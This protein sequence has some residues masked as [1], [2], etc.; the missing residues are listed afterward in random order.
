MIQKPG[1]YQPMQGREW[2]TMCIGP[3]MSSSPSQSHKSSKLTPIDAFSQWKPI[4]SLLDVILTVKGDPGVFTVD[5]LRL[6]RNYRRIYNRLMRLLEIYLW[7]WACVKETP[8]LMAAASSVFTGFLK[9]RSELMALKLL[10]SWTPT[11]RAAASRMAATSSSL[12]SEKNKIV[13][14][15]CVDVNWRSGRK[16][17]A[18]GVKKSVFLLIKLLTMNFRLLQPRE[19]AKHVAGHPTRGRERECVLTVS[20]RKCDVTETQR[21]SERCAKWLI[22][23]IMP[24]SWMNPRG[25]LKSFFL[26]WRLIN[27][28]ICRRYRRTTFTHLLC[29]LL[30]DGKTILF[31]NL[32][33]VRTD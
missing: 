33:Q 18:Q 14:I 24:E 7:K 8:V 17:T 12:M 9:G 23:T 6:S 28:L 25:A 31:K 3:N 20:L 27:P 2:K 30:M 13:F 22:Q 21:R 26:H 19:R 29:S 4:T 32:T 15:I 16:L 1:W 10:K 11:S 5:S